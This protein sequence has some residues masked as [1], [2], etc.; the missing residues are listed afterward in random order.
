[1]LTNHKPLT[2]SLN[3]KP[4]R[5]SPRQVRQL[6]FISQFTTDIHHVAGRG[7]PVADAL[8]CLEANAVE[9]VHTSPSIDFEAMAKAQPNLE[10]LSSS[11]ST[12]QLARIPMPMC[13]DTLLCDT[14]TGTPHPYV[15][16]HFRR[17]V[18]NSLHDLSHP[19][20]RATQRLVTARFVWS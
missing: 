7:N 9:L 3:S 4:D 16:E 15:P 20:V 5:H 12:L 19:G 14:S 6:D 2:H 13:S 1:M 8:S 17:I 11:N 10:K 18:F